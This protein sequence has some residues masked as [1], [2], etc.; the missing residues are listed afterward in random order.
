MKL[1]LTVDPMS[2]Y[3]PAAMND[4]LFCKII[5]GKIPAEIVY[6][7]ENVVAFKDINPQAPVHILVIPTKHIEKLTDPEA[8][9]GRM[10]S[11]IFSAIQKIAAENDLEKGFRVVTNCGAEAGQTVFHLHFHVLGKRPLTWPPG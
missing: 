6:R 10:L 1:L 8:N 7:G 4:C 5:A 2:V 3:N 11:E 9:D